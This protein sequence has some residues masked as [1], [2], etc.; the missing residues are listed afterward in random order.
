MINY[1][2]ISEHNQLKSMKENKVVFWGN[3]ADILFMNVTTDVLDLSFFNKKIGNTFGV[4][5]Y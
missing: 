4:Q 2:P 3:K 1:P 5:H